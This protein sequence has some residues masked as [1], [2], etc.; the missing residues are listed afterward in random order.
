M[1]YEQITIAGNIGSVEIQT[2]KSQNRYLRMS[3][4]VNK[5]S[6]EKKKTTWYSVLL[7]GKMVEN[8]DTLVS[9]F[10][11]GRLVIVA[12][13]PQVEAFIKKDGSAGLDNTIIANSLPQ[14]LD[15]NKVDSH[16]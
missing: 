13:R 10:T 3:V 11:P 15:Y 7:F 12:G 14:L 1:S 16:H 5:G 9:I 2:S 4:A 6:G 8:I